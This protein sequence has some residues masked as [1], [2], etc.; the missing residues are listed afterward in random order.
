M[1]N[2]NNKKPRKII[3]GWQFGTAHKI[4]RH[5]NGIAKTILGS[6][7]LLSASSVANAKEPKR[8]PGL[9]PEAYVVMNENGDILNQQN[10]TN[11]IRPAS[12][13]KLMT[14]YLTMEALKNNRIRLDDKI[15]MTERGYNVRL[16]PRNYRRAGYDVGDRFTVRRSLE[17]QF[18]FSANDVAIATA[19]HVA[20]ASGRQYG[21]VHFVD[22][23]N[24]KARELGMNNTVFADA[25]GI[26][27]N[28]K[29]TARDMVL[30]S[31]AMVR[32]FPE[33]YDGNNAFP[34]FPSQKMVRLGRFSKAN[35]NS[36]VRY[37]PYF[38]GDLTTNQVIEISVEGHKTGFTFPTGFCLVTSA[39]GTNQLTGEKQ[40]LHIAY[41]GGSGGAYRSEKVLD[42][43]AQSFSA[44][45]GYA[46]PITESRVSYR[47]PAPRLKPP[48]R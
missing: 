31:M 41:F 1:L 10:S 14:L 48:Q 35:T 34:D 7:I 39:I 11:T 3:Q 45:Y 19:A 20:R 43:F 17:L 28:S 16:S 29:T 23:M 33:L 21:E 47:P 40:R 26:K 2:K 8:W 9:Q 32:D 18:V 5:F 30:L 38:F 15:T 42:L 24:E 25:S 4:S 46:Y 13:V 6:F 27:Y 44:R 12:T 37:G 22:M 36:L